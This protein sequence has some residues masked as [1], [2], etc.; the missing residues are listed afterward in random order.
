MCRGI[1]GDD[2]KTTNKQHSSCADSVLEW[3]LV[4]WLNGYEKRQ[5][6]KRLHILIPGPAFHAHD[7][8]DPEVRKS[9]SVDLHSGDCFN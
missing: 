1:P 5:T 4:W 9:G 3:Y 8:V 2:F 6:L 7:C